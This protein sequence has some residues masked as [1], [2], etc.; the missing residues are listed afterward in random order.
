MKTEKINKKL[1]QLENV[2]KPRKYFHLLKKSG[3]PMHTCIKRTC[4]YID[5]HIRINQNIY[6]TFK[7]V[8]F[9]YKQ[10]YNLFT[11]TFLGFAVS[12]IIS[13][14]G[15]DKSIS[16]PSYSNVSEYIAYCISLLVT[17]LIISSAI[18]LLISSVKKDYCNDYDLF[19]LPYERSRIVKLIEND[20]GK[21]NYNNTL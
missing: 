20:I 19:V 11:S 3:Q 12:V 13:A 9:N 2:Y 7:T 6:K 21:N 5:K 16:N 1:K 8:D 17:A 14:V 18:C 15:L 4:S 10:L